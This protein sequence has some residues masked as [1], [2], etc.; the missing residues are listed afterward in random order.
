MRKI[1]LELDLDI[2]EEITIE[3]LKSA[4]GMLG[5]SKHPEDIDY[6]KKLRK[7]L[8][9]VLEYYGERVK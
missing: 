8:K 3:E 6:D 4:Y 5:C 9:R 7:A 1:L 2:A